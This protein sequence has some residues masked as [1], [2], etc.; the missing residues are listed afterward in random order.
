MAVRVTDRFVVPAQRRWSRMR[1][2]LDATLTP[3]GTSEAPVRTATIDVSP[4]GALL[5]HLPTL[6]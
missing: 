3:V 1:I 2:R 6:A 5:R 4:T